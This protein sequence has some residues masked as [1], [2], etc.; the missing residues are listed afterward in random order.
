MCM[1]AYVL[2]NCQLYHGVH[3][4]FRSWR[5]DLP[6]GTCALVS[7]SIEHPEAELNGAIQGVVLA[8]HYLIEPCGSGKSRVTHISRIDMR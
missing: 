7:T 1:T 3:P 4:Y 5:K 6:K 2:L 8:S